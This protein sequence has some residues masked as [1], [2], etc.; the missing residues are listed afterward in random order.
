MKMIMI[1]WCELIKMKQTFSPS[2]LVSIWNLLLQLLV[3]FDVELSALGFSKLWNGNQKA[4]ELNKTCFKYKENTLTKK[5][6]NKENNTVK[7][8][9]SLI[10]KSLDLLIAEFV[11]AVP[12]SQRNGLLVRSL[13][14]GWQYTF[15]I[16]KKRLNFLNH[17]YKM[18][19]TLVLKKHSA[20]DTELSWMRLISY[21]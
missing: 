20:P 19:N 3:L 4:I 17:G 6:K 2:D 12:L 11:T 7:T 8:I 9:T 21:A 14:L 5:S 15:F 13:M 16:C 18:S 1:S 10:K